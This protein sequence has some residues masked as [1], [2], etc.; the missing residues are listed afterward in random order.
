MNTPSTIMY[1]FNKQNN[2]VWPVVTSKICAGWKKF[3]E[4]SGTLCGRML[5]RR[6]KGRQ[7]KACVGSVTSYGAEC[8]KIQT[9]NIMWMQTNEMRMIWMMC[10]KTF[11]DEIANCV[12]RKWTDVENIDEQLRGHRL[13]CLGNFGPIVWNVR[14]RRPTK[15]WKE[16][17]KNG[18]TSRNLKLEDAQN[19]DKWRHRCRLVD[20]DDSGWRP[21]LKKANGN[22]MN[23]MI[24]TNQT[25]KRQD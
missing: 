23:W 15:T 3:Q 20:P 13:R 12:L 2:Q 6:L 21:G 24:N 4:F 10:G 1:I 17:V 22:E 19:R 8:W 18:M 7:H 16:T 5:S 11:L 25:K 9:A 14:R